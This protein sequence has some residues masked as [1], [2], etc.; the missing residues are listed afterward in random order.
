MRKLW[1]RWK[2]SVFLPQTSP[3]SKS[4]VL[5]LASHVGCY[6]VRS[7]SNNVWKSFPALTHKHIFSTTL[8]SPCCWCTWNI[9]DDDDLTFACVVVNGK[10]FSLWV[11]LFPISRT[12][13][14]HC[15][16]GGGGKVDFSFHFSRCCWRF[17]CFVN[18]LFMWRWRERR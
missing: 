17:F 2:K 14:S 5:I 8:F 16:F 11:W 13:P 18:M 9:Y 3:I 12:V 4:T 6:V 15:T 1:W 7:C 10:K